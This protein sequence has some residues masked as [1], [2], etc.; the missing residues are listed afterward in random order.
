[1]ATILIV[2]DSPTEMFILKKAVEESGHSVITAGNGQE[3]VER[4]L[5]D[6]PDLIL[7]DVVMPEMNGFQATRKISKNPD[8][9]TIPVILVTT[10]DQRTD[11]E[12]GMRQGATDYLVKPVDLKELVSKVNSHLTGKA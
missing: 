3:G 11:R 4:A 2:D 8:T 12:W 10:K 5:Q 9:A 6:R 7:M 1:M